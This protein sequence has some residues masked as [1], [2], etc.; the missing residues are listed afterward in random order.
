MALN[1][2]FASLL[3][4]LLIVLC[5][6]ISIANAQSSARSLEEKTSQPVEEFQQHPYES[7]KQMFNDYFTGIMKTNGRDGEPLL[8]FAISKIDLSM[9]GRITASVA[10]DY[11]DGLGVLPEAEYALVR[12]D[13]RYQVQKQLCVFDMDIKSP[14]YQSV[15]CTPDFVTDEDSISV[16]F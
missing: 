14:N 16:R 6:G 9:P 8:G 2:K 10:L 7:A 12:T 11:G 3:V 4:G 13:G 15:Q 5:L 1:K